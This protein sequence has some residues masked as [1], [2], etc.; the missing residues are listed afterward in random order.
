MGV[1]LEEG[2]RQL[3]KDEVRTLYVECSNWARHYHSG[4]WTAIAF[5]ITA[6]LAGLTLFNASD[7]FGFTVVGVACLVLLQA[8]D[9]FAD[10]LRVQWEQYMR[11][12]NQIESK[13]KLR[14]QTRNAHGPLVSDDKPEVMG[15]GRL[16]RKKLVSASRMVWALALVAKWL[17]AVLAYSRGH[18]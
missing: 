6:S 17:P 8:A 15:E 1:Q 9:K 16:R 13:W 10:V 2:L 14:D 7:P 12:L 18:R 5:G 4:L 11:V 3:E